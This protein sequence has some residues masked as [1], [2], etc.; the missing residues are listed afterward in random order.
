MTFEGNSAQQELQ[1]INDLKKIPFGQTVPKHSLLL[2]YWFTKT[3]NIDQ[4]NK[5]TLTF[6]PNTQFGCHY[7]GNQEDVLLPLPTGYQYYTVGNLYTSTSHELP[8][9]IRNPP[10]KEYKG[11]NSDRIVFSAKKQN[12]GVYKI[13]RVYL[14]QHQGLSSTSYDPSNTYQLSTQLLQQIGQFSSHNQ[15]SLQESSLERLASLLAQKML[16][17]N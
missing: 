13:N 4:W 17:Q 11:S 2:L 6:D 14:T 12:S 3:V 5:I 7:Y 16:L 1:S 10:V 15:T 9:Y 8:D